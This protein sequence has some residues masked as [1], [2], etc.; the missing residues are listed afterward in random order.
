MQVSKE[1]SIGHLHDFQKKPFV[2]KLRGGGRGGGGGWGEK[3]FFLRG[4]NINFNIV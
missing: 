3:D 4:L 1:T 2:K